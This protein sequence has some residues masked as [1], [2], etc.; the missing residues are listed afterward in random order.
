MT[1]DG[2]QPL[3]C[4]ALVSAYPRESD[5]RAGIA[6]DL[7]NPALGEYRGIWRTPMGAV[8]HLFSDVAADALTGLTLISSALPG[9]ADATHLIPKEQP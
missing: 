9:D 4:V 5:A 3:T 6:Q 2:P 7:D 1:L 8:V